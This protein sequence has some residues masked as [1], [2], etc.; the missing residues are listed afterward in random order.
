M[1]LRIYVSVLRRIPLRHRHSPSLKI[2]LDFRRRTNVRV[3]SLAP[4]PVAF[5]KRC[6]HRRFRIAKYFAKR[7][8]AFRPHSNFGR[9]QYMDRASHHVF[10]FDRKCSFWLAACNQDISWQ[11]L[12]A[13]LVLSP[14]RNV[15][16]SHLICLVVETIFEMMAFGAFG[17][18]SGLAGNIQHY[19]GSTRRHA[20]CIRQTIWILH[21]VKHAGSQQTNKTHLSCER[22]LFMHVLVRMQ[23]LAAWYHI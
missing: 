21:L 7:K 3:F 15:N 19:C 16:E 5:Q 20:T 11:L 4:Q 2:Y 23:R 14:Q 1:N 8:N 22:L 17:I 9:M 6:K 13:V 12:R 10:R 18:P